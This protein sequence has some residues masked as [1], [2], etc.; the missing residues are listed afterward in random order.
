MALHARAA[1]QCRKEALHASKRNARFYFRFSHKNM[2]LILWVAIIRIIFNSSSIW[3]RARVLV[4]KGTTEGREW[5]GEAKEATRDIFHFKI[6]SETWMLCV[7]TW[8]YSKTCQVNWFSRIE[9]NSRVNQMNSCTRSRSPN[10]QRESKA[11]RCGWTNGIKGANSTGASKWKNTHRSWDKAD[12]NVK[13][14][15]TWFLCGTAEKGD[16]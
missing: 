1:T 9:I 3:W 13:C 14:N 7:S 16:T 4:G 5:R 8:I 15:N 11:K 12:E 2:L 6:A 10:D